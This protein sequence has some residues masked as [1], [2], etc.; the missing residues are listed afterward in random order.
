MRD[1]NNFRRDSWRIL[2][3][4]IIFN[5][6]L[7]KMRSR[8]SRQVRVNEPWVEVLVNRWTLVIFQQ[9]RVT[10][11]RSIGDLEGW[12]RAKNHL[13]TGP[14]S[15][16]LSGIYEGRKHRCGIYGYLY[17]ITEILSNTRTGLVLTSECRTLVKRGN[18]GKLLCGV[19]LQTSSSYEV[20]YDLISWY[21]AISTIGRVTY[22]YYRECI[23]YWFRDKSGGKISEQAKA[24]GNSR[25]TRKEICRGK[26]FPGRLYMPNSVLSWS[27]T[28][29]M[30]LQTRRFS[31]TTQ[32]NRDSGGG[33]M[34]TKIQWPDPK[35][36]RDIQEDVYKK[37]VELV[38]IAEKCGIHSKEVQRMQIILSRSLDFAL[39][40]V[41]KTTMN[42]G[43][44]TP[45]VDNVILSSSEEKIAMVEKIQKSIVSA[46]YQSGPVKGVKIPKANGK[47]RLLGIPT[48]TDR[49]L[50]NLMNLVL[51]PLVERYS[52]HHSYGYRKHRS[53][54]HA[55]GYLRNL[56]YSR[57]NMQDK[58]I[59]DAD[60]KGFFDNISH[61]WLI[62]N[63][64]LPNI[65]KK[66]VEKWLKARMFSTEGIVDR[67]L[68][69]PQGGIISPTLANFTLNGLEEVVD[70]SIK[71]ITKS[72]MKTKN[73]KSGLKLNFPCSWATPPLQ[74]SNAP[75]AVEHRAPCRWESGPLQ[76]SI[77]QM[78]WNEMKWTEM[79]WAVVTVRF[80]D[81][82]L[83]TARSKYLIKT[84]ILPQIEKFLKI[85][86]LEL[87]K[88]K[89][90]ILTLKEGLDFLGYTLKYREQWKVREHFFKERI[91]KNGIALYPQKKK[92]Y[93]IIAK[94]REIF[95]K[96]YNDTAYTLITKI[97]PI[98]RGWYGYFNLSQSSKFR[99]YVRQ[100]V[101]SFCVKWAMKK[102]PNWGWR[103]IV[104]TYFLGI[105]HTGGLRKGLRSNWVFRGLTKVDSRYTDKVG[106]GKTIYLIS[107]TDV[108]ILNAA[109]TSIPVKLSKI[110]AYHP[111]A[112]LLQEFN[113]KNSELVNVKNLKAK[114]WKRQNG[115]CTHCSGEIQLNTNIVE[116]C[117]ELHHIIPI[118]LGGSKSNIKN[119]ELIHYEC[120]KMKHKAAE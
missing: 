3:I 82:F 19:G 84:F 41:R 114:V 23:A 75:L 7:G 26:E 73:L 109:S 45:G 94:L 18:L 97:N 76:L 118:S 95:R 27:N 12:A 32:D 57:W 21:K 22:L 64:P 78:K 59:L 40:A 85:R 86:G 43:S 35:Q 112:N 92:V 63:L 87:S 110:H 60:I 53:E 47:T 30:S 70:N 102:H 39:L 9:N 10:S 33:R 48:I 103:R 90:K 67:E 71:S 2:N 72:V 37:Q 49:C 89:T 119:L 117:P 101:F 51:E 1:V 54:K 91:G 83:V 52:D 106:K 44:K 66:I 88:E 17:F 11:N 25:D 68:G 4:S 42:S 58:Y 20:L 99:G 46:S 107:P 115:K 105:K 74:L 56:F 62:T 34:K 111:E 69:T 38:H 100:A 120:H 61:E 13:K 14:T 96:N 5:D 24:L 104:N 79:K 93:N 28:N 29:S 77:G 6:L 16:T 98:L 81:D 80:A 15:V 55:L 65:H 116:L 50:Q 36:W 113:G 108:P 8:L 31:T